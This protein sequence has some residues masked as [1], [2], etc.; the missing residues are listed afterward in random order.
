[1]SRPRFRRPRPG[2][3]LLTGVRVVRRSRRRAGRVQQIVSDVMSAEHRTATCDELVIADLGR[4]IATVRCILGADPALGVVR[5]SQRDGLAADVAM[6]ALR[7]GLLDIL[8]GT[9]RWRVQAYEIGEAGSS[10]ATVGSGS[11]SG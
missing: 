1:L 3:T 4:V 10:P 6:P 2:R 8:Q 7:P 5:V 11:G 9:D